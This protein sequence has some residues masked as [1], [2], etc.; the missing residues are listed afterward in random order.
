M[1]PNQK[2]LLLLASQALANGQHQTGQ[3]D[4]NRIL[5]VKD[6]DNN[7]AFVII[8]RRPY[9]VH[10]SVQGK[11][12]QTMSRTDSWIYEVREENGITMG[13][14]DLSTGAF[15]EDRFNRSIELSQFENM[16]KSA[17]SGQ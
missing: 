6:S 11:P 1:K 2:K 15:H 4:G 9:N 8:E 17:S 12:A 14:F 7:E 16:S 5:S 3:L 13:Y 10:A